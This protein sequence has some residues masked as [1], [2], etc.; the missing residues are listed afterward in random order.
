M[1]TFPLLAPPSLPTGLEQPEVASTQAGVFS[2]KQARAEGFSD[3]RQRRLIR[4]GLWAPVAG[5]VL[6]NRAVPIG[7]W[8]RAFAVALHGLVVSH[9]TAGQLWSLATGAELHGIGRTRLDDQLVAHHLDLVPSDVVEVAGIR[10]T[11]PVRTLVDLLCWHALV[12]MIPTV[13]DGLRRGLLTA[14]GLA[15]AAQAAVGRWGA[16]R[17]RS[18][19]ATCAGSPYSFLEW[20]AQGM[21]RTLGPDGPS[22]WSSTMGMA[23]SVGSTRCTSRR[24]RSSS[25]M[26]GPTTAATGSSTIGPATRGSPPSAT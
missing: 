22:T 25:S 15:A 8:Q 21:I 18:I 26:G 1:G 19:A 6:R 4:S 5:R 2:R 16:D 9:D 10:V 3:S 20:R 23:R 11:N 14:T 17:A 13:T 7:P 12:D 24:G